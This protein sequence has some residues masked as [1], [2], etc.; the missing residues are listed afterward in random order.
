MCD[1]A[2]KLSLSML[3][4]GLYKVLIRCEHFFV[5]QIRDNSDSVSVDGLK[6]VI[7]TVFVTPAVPPVLLDGLSWSQP[8]RT[9]QFKVL[10]LSPTSSILTYWGELLWLP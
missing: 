1:D 6:P 9:R 10:R 3:F 2:S 7:S 4:R 8:I 5:L